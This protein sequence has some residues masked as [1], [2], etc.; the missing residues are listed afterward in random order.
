[1]PDIFVLNGDLSMGLFVGVCA[2]ALAA[3]VGK[4]L[5]GRDD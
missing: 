4:M 5:A 1:M 2:V 3:W